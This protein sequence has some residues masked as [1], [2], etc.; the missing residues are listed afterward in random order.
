MA[1]NKI[2]PFAND[3][4][5]ALPLYSIQQNGYI[6]IFAL[7]NICCVTPQRIDRKKLWDV[8]KSEN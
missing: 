5:V 7:T 3:R 2:M 6:E 8:E 1:A 4:N